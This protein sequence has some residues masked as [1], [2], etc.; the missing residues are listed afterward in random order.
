MGTTVSLVSTTTPA[1]DHA[2]VT[3]ALERAFDEITRLEALMTTWRPDS[4]VSRV[5]AAAGGRAIAVSPETFSVLQKS[6]WISDRSQGTF[7]I[8][9]ASMG[10]LWR[11]DPNQVAEL[12]APATV[13]AARAKID[14]RRVVLDETDRTV[15]LDSPDTRINLGGIAKGYAID[16]V[17]AIL[18]RA[19]L[20]SFTAQAGGDLY[21]AGR[22]PDGKAWRVGIRDPRGK[23]GAF[24]AMLEVEDHAFSTAGDYE[25][26]FVRG[27]RRYHHIIDP[28]TGYPA[29]ASRSVTIWAKDALTADALD[30]AVFIL[31]PAEGLKLVESLDDCGAV[32][33]DQNNRVWISKRL[34]GRVEIRHQPTDGI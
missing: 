4:E 13:A 9:F 14:Y 20:G 10:K 32:I 18:R 12:P 26:A 25:R 1:L 27:G 34:A 11:F 8:T 16:R 30:D 33:V 21:V 31:G 29:T 3:A 15:R 22:K 2:A 6:R 5:N 23:A 24:F 28:R 19:G 17:A 7:D